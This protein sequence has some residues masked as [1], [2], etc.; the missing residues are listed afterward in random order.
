MLH[1]PVF[2][3][4]FLCFLFYTLT[5]SQQDIIGKIAVRVDSATAARTQELLNAGVPSDIEAYHLA[6]QGIDAKAL[7]E[8]KTAGID[9]KKIF[10]NWPPRTVRE[11][12]IFADA[13]VLGR[14]VKQKFVPDASLN[15]YIYVTVE[16]WLKGS[17][18]ET[19]TIVLRTVG[20]GPTKEPGIYM[21]IS[22]EVKFAK[23]ER[24]LLLL[25]KANFLLAAREK[26]PYETE[27]Y[28]EDYP[29]MYMDVYG[30]KLVVKRDW[31]VEV[32]DE[33]ETR[34]ER[35]DLI[36][37]QILDVT[38]KMESVIKQGGTKHE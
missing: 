6:Y 16:R 34:K 9:V 4:S 17:P 14:V 32:V 24:V 12:A 8:L 22:H 28:K 23:G 37:S 10:E 2:V 11:A 20:S 36:V 19:N 3:S 15:K 1:R 31:L 29:Y 27:T 5:Y 30:N 18:T 21:G 35:L 7:E 25:S 13:I 38:S 33:R 26:A